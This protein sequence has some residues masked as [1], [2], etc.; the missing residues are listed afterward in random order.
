LYRATRRFEAADQTYAEA[1]AIH[2]ETDN[3]R[4]LG[5]TRCDYAL[6][7]LSQ[8]RHEQAVTWWRKGA[9]LL[10]QLGDSVE[11]ERTRQTMCEACARAGVPPFGT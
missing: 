2:A 7:L 8:G 1:L 5:I 6:C 11:L 3:Q 10:L 4:F 9:A